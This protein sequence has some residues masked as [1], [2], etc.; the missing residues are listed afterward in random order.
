QRVSSR[1]PRRAQRRKR[2]QCKQQ[3]RPL[4]LLG[5]RR[6]AAHA[7]GTE[8]RHEHLRIR[9]IHCRKGCSES[10]SSCHNANSRHRIT[11]RD[12]NTPTGDALESV[13]CDVELG[14]VPPHG[15]S[16]NTKVF[17]VTMKVAALSSATKAL[18]KK[19][20]G[21]QTRTKDAEHDTPAPHTEAAA[22]IPGNVKLPVRRELFCTSRIHK[23]G[24][25]LGGG[26][27]PDKSLKLSDRIVNLNENVV[28]IAPTK[29]LLLNTK[30]VRLVMLDAHVEGIVPISL[31]FAAEMEVIVAFHSAY[32]FG[33][34]PINKLS[35]T[36]ID[37]T[38]S[39]ELYSVGSEPSI[40]L[41][42]NLLM[43]LFHAAYA[44]GRV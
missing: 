44:G 42:L 1:S 39:Q 27:D 30:P 20:A 34:G 33:S 24:Y 13:V 19:E 37:V 25:A 29:E 43:L 8:N 5:R 3:H 36:S 14:V 2:A 41:L 11:S 17:M 18:R 23:R 38:L 22:V 21:A 10:D 35:S 7:R 32:A 28:G 9:S 16:V 40:E 31:L 26:N 12:N 15:G 4:P 6:C